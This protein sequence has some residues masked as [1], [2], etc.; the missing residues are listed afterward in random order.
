MPAKNPYEGLREQALRAG[1]SP[2]VEALPS[3]VAGAL[4]EIGLRDGSATILAMADGTVS[5]YTSGGGGILGYD[6]KPAVREAG[7]RFL[8]AAETFA[9]GFALAEHVAPPRAGYVRFLLTT[10]DG[11]R[12]STE[13][14]GSQVETRTHP[15]MPLYAAGQGVVTAIRLAGS[16]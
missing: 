12:A 14:E 2:G 5:M 15:L 4:M 16:R 3:G 1:T 9:P 13:V 8:A 7:Q 10:R 6:A 11:V